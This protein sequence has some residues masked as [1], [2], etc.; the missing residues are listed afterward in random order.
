MTAIVGHI[1]RLLLFMDLSAHSSSLLMRNYNPFGITESF[2]CHHCLLLYSG[3]LNWNTRSASNCVAPFVFIRRRKRLDTAC[4]P[5]SHLSERVHFDFVRS[6]LLVVSAE[7]HVALLRLDAS[8]KQ[9]L[10]EL[11]TDEVVGLCQTSQQRSVSPTRLHSRLL[12]GAFC[13]S[14]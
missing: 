12:F 9:S 5:C 2:Q 3:N 7:Q 11:R 1:F 6:C 13:Q 10:W 8:C 4:L 14:C